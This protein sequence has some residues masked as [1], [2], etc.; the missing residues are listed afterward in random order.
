M[1]KGISLVDHLGV[2]PREQPL[3]D[4]RSERDELCEAV[5]EEGTDGNENNRLEPADPKEALSFCRP[6]S[7][8][9]FAVRVKTYTVINW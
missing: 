5:E 9:D 1:E 3:S 7:H 2:F 8:A 6:W 4:S